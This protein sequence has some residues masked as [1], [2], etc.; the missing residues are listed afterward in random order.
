MNSLNRDD[1][2]QRKPKGLVRLRNAATRPVK[3]LGYSRC[4]RRWGL[5]GEGAKVGHRLRRLGEHSR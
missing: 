4:Q 3:A 1:V 2:W 5:T